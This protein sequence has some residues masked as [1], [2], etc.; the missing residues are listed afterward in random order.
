VLVVLSLFASEG[1]LVIAALGF[2]GIGVQ[3]PTPE[4]GTMLSEGRP[5]FTDHP[6][7]MIFPGLA[8]ALLILGFNLL[9]D[10]LR[11]RLDKR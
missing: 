5:D 2:L 3:P 11:D 1:L 10:G 9:G 4:W 8:I 7:V 6:L